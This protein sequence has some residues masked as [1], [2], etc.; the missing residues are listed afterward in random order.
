[1]ITDE[2]HHLITNLLDR[3]FLALEQKYRKKSWQVIERLL[4]I[5][6]EREHKNFFDIYL[7]TLANYYGPHT[8][9]LNRTDAENFNTH[10]SGKFEE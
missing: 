3:Q 8:T 10:M 7:N 6:Y 4:K 1:M 9:Y 2:K 5:F